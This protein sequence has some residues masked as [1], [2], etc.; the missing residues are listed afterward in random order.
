LQQD[1][2]ISLLPNYSTKQLT[3]QTVG[4]KF[5]TAVM[6]VDQHV[7]EDLVFILAECVP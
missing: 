2:F 4:D 5:I 7:N 1:T 3:H 6:N